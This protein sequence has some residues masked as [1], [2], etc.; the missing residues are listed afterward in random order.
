MKRILLILL[1]ALTV[2]VGRAQDAL[3]SKYENTPGVET[4]F[5]SKAMFRMMPNLRVGPKNI[6][7]IVS[8]LDRLQILN[9]ERPSMVRTI[10]DNA[11]AIYRR[12]RYEIVMQANSDGERTT[13]YMK[14]RGRGKNEFALLNVEKDEVSII[15]LLGNV[16]LE[17]I[18]QITDD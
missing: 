10:T 12:E 14:S 3:F 18:K 5:I 2:T 17:D 15:N 16:S 9:C 8:K 4:V 6:G 7:K 11:A 13:I 1:I